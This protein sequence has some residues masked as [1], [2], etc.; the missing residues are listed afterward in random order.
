MQTDERREAAADSMEMEL[1]KILLY[2]EEQMVEQPE[3]LE[4]A[5]EQL[6]QRDNQLEQAAEQSGQPNS[7]LGQPAEQLRQSDNQL[8]QA[9][10]PL[11]QQMKPMN[12]QSRQSGQQ[13]EQLAEATAADAPVKPG[14]AMEVRDLFFSYGK[15]KVLK[16]T[17]FVIEKGKITTIMGANG[18]GKSTLFSLMTK[19]LPQNKGK[20]FL[21]G[22]NIHN[23]RLNEFARNVAIVH[24]YNTAADDITVE[25]LVSFGRTPYLGL[26]GIKKEQDEKFIEWAMQV[27]NVAE[28]RDR[29]LSRLSGGQRQRVWIAMALAQGTEILFLDEPTTYLDIR[30][31]IEILELIQ[32]LNREYGM[33]II[34]VLHDINQA[35]YFS[36]RVIGLNDGKVIV[37]GAPDEVIT[38]ETLRALFD[39]DLEVTEVNG[40]KFVLT[41]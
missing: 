41:V 2:G 27:T 23:L 11:N 13:S 1:P 35:I 29:E 10:E 40:R 37:D 26:M 9:A 18:C 3:Q 12:E 28:F 30:Y 4:Q 19:N 33:T 17:S 14:K 6:R 38:T 31:Q 15:N 32:K 25:R 39:I 8:G 7:Q 5:T 16:G 20:I 34:M 24:Q 36:D 21:K 22:K